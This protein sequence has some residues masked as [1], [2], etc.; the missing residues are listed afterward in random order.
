[1]PFCHMAP[2]SAVHIQNRQNRRDVYVYT[3]NI[4]LL[5]SKVLPQKYFI[6]DSQK[7]LLN[8]ERNRT[9]LQI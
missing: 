9:S 2:I 5:K 1:M 6:V 8:F 3:E 4:K 7:L